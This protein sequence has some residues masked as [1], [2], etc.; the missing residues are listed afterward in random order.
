M[1]SAA[2]PPKKLPSVNVCLSKKGQTLGCFNETN[3]TK[4]RKGNWPQQN[5]NKLLRLAAPVISSAL[6]DFFNFFMSISIISF[7]GDCSPR[8]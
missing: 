6:A 4:Y 8:Y 1:E 7:N 5:I 2:R 3:R